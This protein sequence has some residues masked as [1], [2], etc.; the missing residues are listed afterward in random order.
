MTD[1]D[2]NHDGVQNR[3][4][5]FLGTTG[6]SFTAHL[7]PIPTARLS[8]RWRPA[9]LATREPTALP[10]D[11]KYDSVNL[12]PFLDGTEKTAPH[13]QLFWRTSRKIWVVREGDSKLVRIGTKPDELYDLG[14]DIGETN[15]LQGTEKLAATL[16]AWDKELVPPVFPGPDGK[17]KPA[18]A[19]SKGN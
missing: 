11:R 18:K 19:K 10:T 4:D 13:D 9:R 8:G 16:D 6:S 7:P 12:I 3:I 2:H 1:Q 14:S 5:D 17:K 15:V